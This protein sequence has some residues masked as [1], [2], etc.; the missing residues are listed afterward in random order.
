[1]NSPILTY[2]SPGVRDNRPGTS[3]RRPQAALAQKEKRMQLKLRLNV[4]AL[5]ASFLFVAAV[6]LGMI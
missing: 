1:M 6:A 2:V 3:K 5:V 4:L